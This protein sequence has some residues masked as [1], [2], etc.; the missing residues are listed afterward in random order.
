[1][2]CESLW[3]AVR[4]T[5]ENRKDYGVLTENDLSLRASFIV[6]GNLVQYTNRIAL[7][8]QESGCR[9]D[10][11]MLQVGSDN[12]DERGFRKRLKKELAKLEAVKPNSSGDP[13]P[14]ALMG[15]Q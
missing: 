10:L 9:M 1:M 6:V 14:A 8:E 7:T 11:R 3:A 5:L 15:Q 4:N 13:R 12:S 2:P